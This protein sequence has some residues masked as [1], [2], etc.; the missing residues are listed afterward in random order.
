M[1]NFIQKFENQSAYDAAEHQYP[2]VSLVGT[3]IVY[4]MEAEFNGIIATF[5]VTSTSYATK[6]CGSTENF[7]KL[8][9]DGVQQ[10]TVQ[11]NY[12]FD[13]L[14]EHTVK[15][16]LLDSTTIGT[17]AFNAC[18][19]LTSV[20]IPN[21]VTSIGEFAFSGCTGLTS[22]TIPSGITSIGS[23]AFNGCGGLTSVTVE[24]TTTPT[25]G[26]YVFADTNNCPIYVPTESVEAYQSATNWSE[27]ASRIQ[28]IPTT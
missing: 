5:N 16:T 23:N 7:S 1:A 8:W 6:L 10:D 14:G 20:T 18:T 2:N 28:A 15:Y 9:I 27:Y 17:S 22:I 26:N 25:L 21:S 4:K 13:T 24:A 12:T 19:G 11:K 3:D